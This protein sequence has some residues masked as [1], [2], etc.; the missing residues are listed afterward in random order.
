[1]N[2]LAVARSRERERFLRPPGRP[3]VEA[4]HATFVWHRYALHMHETFTIALVERGGAGFEL[5]GQ[6]CIAPAGSTF[7][8][9]PHRP[10]ALIP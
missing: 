7:V 10:S 1:L 8:I 3:G 6:R 4:L 9:P 5:H 2:D